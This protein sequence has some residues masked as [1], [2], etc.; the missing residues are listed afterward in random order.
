MIP[1]AA[2]PVIDRLPDPLVAT[3]VALARKTPLELLPVVHDVP[4]IM[5][6]PEVVTFDERNSTP[7]P[8]PGPFADS[9][10]IVI[11]PAPFDV[12]FAEPLK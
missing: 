8:T 2:V 11:L 9:P 12:I 3:I 5:T 6:L 4:L 1:F 10:V 7:R